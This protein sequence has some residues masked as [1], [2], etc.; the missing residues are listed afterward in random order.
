MNI[1]LVCPTNY[2]G[3]SA[4]KGIYYPMGTLLVGSL[5]KDTFPSLGVNIFDGELY[6]KEGLESKIDGVDVLGLSA[7]TNN[8]Q[9]CID[10]A[11]FAKDH[12][13]RRVVIGGPHASASIIHN[14]STVPMAELILRNQPSIDVVIVNDG[15]HAFLK[16]LTEIQKWNPRYEGIENL[17]WRENNGEIKHNPRVTPAQPPRVVDMNFSL[18]DLE[19]YWHEH[20]SEF[21]E[22]S[23]KF[24]EGFTH[25][26]CAWREKL[27]CSFC[28]IPYPVNNY[29]IPG[30]FWRDLQEARHQLGIHSFKDYGDCLTGNLERV[31]A[32]LKSRPADMEDVEIGKEVENLIHRR[33]ARPKNYED[34]VQTANWLRL[35]WSEMYREISQPENPQFNKLTIDDK[36]PD[37]N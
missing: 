10:L 37:P 3:A 24:V 30:R 16:Y 6:G 19:R 15:E 26:G 11:R 35:L 25:V 4:T 21:P 29:Q 28:D 31:E 22:M 18:I 9:H 8:Y 1:A 23:E 7:N 5:V 14:N 32:L 12:G 33:V 27:G 13:T 2:Y 20:K 17:S 36:M 34:P